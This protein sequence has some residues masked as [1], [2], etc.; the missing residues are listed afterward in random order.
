MKISKLI[1]AV[2]DPTLQRQLDPFMI[3]KQKL[4]RYKM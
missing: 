1:T 3:G 2:A 4:H